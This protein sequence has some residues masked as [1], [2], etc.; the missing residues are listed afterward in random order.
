MQDGPLMLHHARD[1][2]ASC[3]FFVKKNTLSCKRTHWA[4]EAVGACN[5]WRKDRIKECVGKSYCSLVAAL[6]LAGLSNGTQV[7]KGE[8]G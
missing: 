5:W 3:N 6:A 7:A 1:P 4:V 2:A 8:K